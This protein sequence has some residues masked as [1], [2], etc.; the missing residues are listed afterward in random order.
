MSF[1]SERQ[2]SGRRKNSSKGK[3]KRSKHTNAQSDKFQSPMNETDC[4]YANLA[5]IKA[6]GDELK[7]LSLQGPPRPGPKP[8]QNSRAHEKLKYSAARA[9]SSESSGSDEQ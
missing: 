5:F 8:K 3:K 6:Q 1:E 2:N 9:L 7:S 4:I